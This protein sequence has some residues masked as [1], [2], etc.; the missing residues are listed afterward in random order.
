MTFK[1]SH[2]L[3]IVSFVLFISGCAAKKTEPQELPGSARADMFKGR[4]L[5]TTGK[6]Q[7]DYC[8]LAMVRPADGPV[9]SQYGNRRL[10]GKRAK[11]RFHKG[12]DIGAKRGTSVVAAA[13]GKVCFV[14]SKRGYG[15]TVDVDHGDGVTTRYAH[16]D[17]I[18]V[19]EGQ[20]VDPTCRLGLVGRT[21]RT[22]GANL[23]FEL[24]DEGRHVNP[25]VRGVWL[26]ETPDRERQLANSASFV[27]EDFTAADDVP[28]GD[29]LVA[30][31]SADAEEASL[32]ALRHKPAKAGKNAKS[33][34]A[35][36]KTQAKA[37]GKPAKTA[38]AQ[39]KAAKPVNAVS[40]QA[41]AKPAAKPKAS[42]QITASA[43]GK[44]KPVANA[45][46]APGKKKSL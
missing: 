14:G 11:T 31:N 39:G 30:V 36:A 33:S 3:I 37:T 8:L 20:Q 21:G 38:S 18:F 24:L 23:H 7:G 5:Q 34:K 41:K 12:I 35:R 9:V 45:K 32:A 27:V 42:G 19:A 28:G 4:P 16:L 2:L 10:G 44:T 46:P 26:N 22:T 15:K 1:T 43:Q 29:E 40:A 6:K 25:L 17:A 13:P